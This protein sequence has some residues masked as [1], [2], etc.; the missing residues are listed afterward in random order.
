MPDPTTKKYP[1]AIQVRIGDD[2]KRRLENWNQSKLIRECVWRHFEAADR[3][4]D[5]L[6]E[7][8]WSGREM[9]IVGAQVTCE[10][11]P[12]DVPIQDVVRARMGADGRP[13]EITGE[14]WD[15]LR[16]SVKSEPVARSVI[17]IGRYRSGSPL[18]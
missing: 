9:H 16:S 10:A 14:R 7:E 11:I 1:N 15:E 3:A 2:L 18:G 12:Y 4:F 5:L 13:P 8:G 6:E 17:A